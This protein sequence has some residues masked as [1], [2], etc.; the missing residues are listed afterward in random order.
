MRY[1]ERFIFQD[2][3]FKIYEVVENG[4][5]RYS[6]RVQSEDIYSYECPHTFE[7]REL[8]V[9]AAKLTAVW[10]S[11]DNLILPACVEDLRNHELL[12]VNPVSRYFFGA[13]PG[14]YTYEFTAN[15]EAYCEFYRDLKRDGKIERKQLVYA[16]GTSVEGVVKA[17]IIEIPQPLV[18]SQFQ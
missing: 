13:K 12:L 8:A 7:T 9:Y 17:H 10:W 2:A 11:L 15:L 6:Y 4:L 3:A 1:T 18:V 14:Q 5:V 16:D